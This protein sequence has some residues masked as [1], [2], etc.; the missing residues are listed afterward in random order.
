MLVR[1]PEKGGVSICTII[2]DDNSN[3]RVKARN[4]SNRGQLPAVVEEPKFLANPSHQ[5][6]VLAR[7]IY[8]LA[9]APKRLSTLQREW[10][11]I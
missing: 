11:V 1:L 4:I 10:W 9:S 7:A 5:K 8:N 2:S 6:K 3:G